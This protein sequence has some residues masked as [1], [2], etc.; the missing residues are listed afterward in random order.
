MFNFFK[1]KKENDYNITYTEN[2]FIESNPVVDTEKSYQ[3][4][5]NNKKTDKYVSHDRDGIYN[6][7]VYNAIVL[8]NNFKKKGIPLDKVDKLHHISL[9]DIYSSIGLND[10]KIFNKLEIISI[11]SSPFFSFEHCEYFPELFAIDIM[12]MDTLNG[13]DLSYL[14]NIIQPFELL[15][16]EVKEADLS[17]LSQCHKLRVLY[18]EFVNCINCDALK[19]LK[20]IDAIDIHSC[21]FDT[22]DF[23]P[24]LPKLTNLSFHFI[25]SIDTQI[26]KQLKN[27][28]HLELTDTLI[29]DISFIEEMP[30][31]EYLRIYDTKIKD[32]SPIR[33]CTKLKNIIIEKNEI[34][35]LDPFADLHSLKS[36]TFKNN[37]IKD[38]S[39]FKDKDNY[40]SFFISD[41]PVSMLSLRK[42]LGSLYYKLNVY[43]RE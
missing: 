42:Q 29:D 5:Q 37:K 40:D 10:L 22:L 33:Y 13:I 14:E 43:D 31:L 32:F 3:N 27:I 19:E 23:L 34:L 41:N 36:I 12:Y 9:T 35:N 24:Y 11:K 39:I 30:N 20:N 28:T 17:K 21:T 1:R 6:E 15:L 38:F 4:K 18:L 8:D 7:D 16:L 2:E 25:N 26:L